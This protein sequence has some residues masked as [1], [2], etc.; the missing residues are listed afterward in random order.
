MDQDK[1]VFSGLLLLPPQAK[2]L[3]KKTWHQRFCQLYKA[4]KFGIERLEIYDGVDE[5]SITKNSSSRIIT[6]ENCVKIAQ[7]HETAFQLITKTASYEFNTITQQS[8]K[9]WL[10]ALQSVAFKDET[11]RITSIEEDNDLYCSSSDEMFN[12][13]LHASEASERCGLY[14]ENYILVLNATAI[15]I[16]DNETNKLLYTWP[17]RFIRRYG[18]REGKFT[19]EAGRKCESGEGIFHLEHSNQKAIFR[20]VASKMKSMKKLLINEANSSILDCGDN[21]FQATLGMEARSHTPLPPSP[22]TSSSAQDIES[23]TSNLTANS[24][25]DSSFE[26][27]L[28]AITNTKVIP[29]KPPRKFIGTKPEGNLKHSNYEAVNKYD[30]VEFRNEAWRTLGTDDIKHTENIDEEEL[31]EYVSWGRKANNSPIEHLN[32]PKVTKIINVSP[33]VDDRYDRLNFFGL[34]GKL[35]VKNSKYQ[36]IPTAPVL[37]AQSPSSFNDYDEVV[38]TMESVRIADDSHLGYAMIR[39]MPKES[40]DHQL[41]NNEPYAVINKPKRV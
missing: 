28:T 17:Y 13:T 29:M 41:Y 36:Q 3:I 8:L 10:A 38:P 5:N 9:E 18:Y 40:I 12:V 6:L 2:L 31:E 34:S 4:S 23:D 37:P 1:P 19:F 11:S 15:Q 21:Q 33:N 24:L 14:P 27:K 30:Q 32:L 26:K 22:T 7:K 25:F 16:R 20:C 39:K 35:N